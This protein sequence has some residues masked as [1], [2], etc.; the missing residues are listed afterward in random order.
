MTTS[1]PEVKRRHR[2]VPVE[3]FDDRKECAACGW[4]RLGYTGISPRYEYRAQ[5]FRFIANR[6]QRDPAPPCSGV[7]P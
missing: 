5:N 1:K 6:K 4:V 2:W 7:K 3:G